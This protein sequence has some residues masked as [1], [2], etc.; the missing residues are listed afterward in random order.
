MARALTVVPPTAREKRQAAEALH[1]AKDEYLDCR[2][3]RHAWKVQGVFYS[4]AEIHRRLVCPRCKTV[5]TDRWTPRGER[6]ARQYSYPKGYETKG[7]RIRPIDVRKEVLTRINE[8][9]GVWET[10]EDMKNSLFDPRSR[11]KRA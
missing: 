2:D 7:V 11:R 6:I 9:G 5:A 8:S 1:E 3:L 4:G 10:E